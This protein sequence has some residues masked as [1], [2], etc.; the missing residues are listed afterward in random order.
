MKRKAIYYGLGVCVI[1]LL[2]L[3]GLYMRYGAKTKVATLNFPDFT[4]EK[5]RR[6]NDNAFVK[7]EPVDL[8]QVEK[9]RRYDMV[10]VRVHGNGLGQRH[11]DAIRSAIAKGVPVFSTES[12]NA[13]INSLDSARLAYVAALMD[14][15]SVRNYRSLFN[16][17][18]R[19]IDGKRWFNGAYEDVVP[20]PADYF[21]HLGEDEFFATYADYQAFY[22]N[23]GLYKPDAPRVVLL[24]GNINMQNSNEEHMAALVRSL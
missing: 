6:A 19:E 24:S 9:I 8:E 5:M 17:I 22:E 21:F 16:Y 12:T 18:R 15:G 14:N 3:C 13:E 10:L 7:I 11:L 20:V 1:A 2:G 4:V 23:K